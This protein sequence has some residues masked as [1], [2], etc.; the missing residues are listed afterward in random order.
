MSFIDDIF[1]IYDAQITGKEAL[2]PPLDQHSL[3]MRDRFESETGTRRER[4]SRFFSDMAYTGRLAL[5]QPETLADPRRSQFLN[6]QTWSHDRMISRHFDRA[7]YQSLRATAV[8]HGVTLNDFL[9][10]RLFQTLPIWNR[11]YQ[12]QNDNKG[13]LRVLIPVNLR[14]RAD[15]CMPLTNRL[16]YV[17][18]SRRSDTV[19][20]NDSLLRSISEENARL[21]RIGIPRRMLQKL[22][23]L[24][25]TG[26]WPL[27]FS[28]R[29]CLATTVFSNLGD[30]TRRFRTRFP[31]TDGLIQIGNLLMTQFEG[32]TAL[33][34]QTRAGIFFNTY[35]NQLT[36]STRFDPTHYAVDDA[37]AFLDLFTAKIMEQRATSPS[38]GRAA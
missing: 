25:R 28:P 31:R 11:R 23:L 17:F 8:K 20:D 26:L 32:T 27:I 36:I 16:S 38:Y 24:Q 4:V 14:N 29:R 34:P 30:P 18:L 21:R 19:A 22:A 12:P 5:C 10:A 1:A 3:S 37:E 35:G 33:R 2:L 9:V 13:W 6:R 15:L 7:T